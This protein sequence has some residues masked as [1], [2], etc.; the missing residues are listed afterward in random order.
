[1][2]GM[3]ATNYLDLPDTLYD[4]EK[5]SKWSKA[6]ETEIAKALSDAFTESC[7]REIKHLAEES[8]ANPGGF[9]LF[10]LFLF[11]AAK[12]T[13]TIGLFA[14]FIGYWVIYLFA[15]SI[16]KS[17]AIHFFEKAKKREVLYRC[18]ADILKVEFDVATSD[19][20]RAAINTFFNY[21]VDHW[22][23]IKFEYTK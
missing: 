2:K 19:E 11:V 3:I 5:F 17:C 4:F 15:K 10:A 18:F 1:M 13:F 14:G 20:Q 12:S 21:A 7:G 23:E 16:A 8:T 22:Y 6:H 9:A